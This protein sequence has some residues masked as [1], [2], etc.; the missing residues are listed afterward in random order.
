MMKP[1]LLGAAVL[2]ATTLIASQ[3]H[4]HRAW[5]LPDTASFS[6]EKPVATFDAAVSNE[7]FNFDHVALDPK[8]FQVIGPDGRAVEVENAA[9][10]RYRG[11]FDVTLQQQGT[12]RVFSASEGLRAM[13]KDADGKRHMY[14]QRGKPF[15]QAEFDKMVPPK[16]D[17][18]VIS[19]YYRRLET[20]VTNG[21][22]SDNVM[23]ITGKGFEMKPVSHP[24]DLYNGEPATFSFMLNGKPVAGAEVV[25]LREGS[26]YRD[27]Q[28]EIKATTND[29][30]EFTIE[31]KGAGR[32]FLEAEYKDNQA[33]AP[34]TERQGTYSAVLEVLPQ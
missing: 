20:F 7:I 18:L 15:V 24:T 2:A 16:A 6:A 5:V 23:Q 12:Y 8:M 28:D 30:G 27:S 17:G 34:A 19:Q 4:A 3:V 25:L 22:P 33:V 13:W 10:L 11:V 9:K 26:R 32:Y 31:W 1:G 29:K 14:P 21:A